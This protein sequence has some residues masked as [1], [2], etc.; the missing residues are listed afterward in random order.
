MTTENKP[1]SGDGSTPPPI[2]QMEAL[3]QQEPPLVRSDKDVAIEYAVYLANAAALLLSFMNDVEEA[4]NKF[5][6]AHDDGEDLFELAGAVE[7]AKIK[8]DGARKTLES[9][10]YEFRMRR[11]LVFVE[12]SR[13]SEA[14]P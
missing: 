8:L 14:A 3:F 12:V 4:I 10:L 7:A 2:E 5:E 1:Y 6:N 9:T 13:D 11:D